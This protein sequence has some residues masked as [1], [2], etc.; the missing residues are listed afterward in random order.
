M[1]IA[2]NCE[3]TGSGL[4]TYY[5]EEREQGDTWR[6]I[7]GENSSTLTVRDIQ[8]PIRFKCI[9]SNEAGSMKSHPAIITLLGK[10]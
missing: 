10:R 1:D 3:G 7:S 5:W 6:N 9:V 4:L 2:L 8:K